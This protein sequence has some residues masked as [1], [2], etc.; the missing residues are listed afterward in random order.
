MVFARLLAQKHFARVSASTS[1]FRL[2][3]E[4]ELPPAN[5]IPPRGVLDTGKDVAGLMKVG[6][7]Q[8]HSRFCHPES[9]EPARQDQPSFSS[10]SFQI[11]ATKPFQWPAPIQQNESQKSQSASPIWTLLR[12]W[13]ELQANTTVPICS[14]L[15]S[16]RKMC[17]VTTSN[18]LDYLTGTSLLTSLRNRARGFFAKPIQSFLSF[19]SGF[20]FSR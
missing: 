9:S 6:L 14:M 17:V 8:P 12:M 11:S 19:S 4:L 3:Q 18:W 2:Q 5:G 13:R 1:S 10:P 15:K 20:T 7:Y 16:Q